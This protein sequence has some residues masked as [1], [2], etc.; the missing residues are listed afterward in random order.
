MESLENEPILIAV[1]DHLTQYVD[2]GE[3]EYAVTLD[4]TAYEAGQII[5]ESIT[6]PDP[7]SLTWMGAYDRADTTVQ[8]TIIAPTYAEARILG[9]RVRTALCGKTRREYIHPLTIPLR[10]VESVTSN[11][12]GHADTDGRTSQWAERY[13]ITFQ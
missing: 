7:D 13:T 3:L 1:R 6:P 12:D 5:V 10:V 9:D 8:V 11:L 2:T 4:P